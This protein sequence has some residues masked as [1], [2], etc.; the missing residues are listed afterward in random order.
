MPKKTIQVLGIFA[1]ACAVATG[2]ENLPTKT[3]VH[4]PLSRFA[5][6]PVPEYVF[7]STYKVKTRSKVGIFVISSS[8]S[9]FG[10]NLAPFGFAGKRYL[11]TAA[12]VI[13]DDDHISD[14]IEVEVRNKIFRDKKNPKSGFI[15]SRMW[16]RAR[17][18]TYD[19]EMDI[20]ILKVEMDLPHIAE[21]DLEPDLKR[22]AP[23]LAV[24]CPSG[25]AITPSWGYLTSKE[26]ETKH[27]NNFWWQA[28]MPIYYGN[29]GGAV[30]NPKSSKIIGICVAI[31]AHKGPAANASFFVSPDSIKMFLGSKRVIKAIK[32]DGKLHPSIQLPEKYNPSKN[33]RE[34]KNDSRPKTSTRVP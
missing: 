1:F 7:A 19:R 30:W 10:V 12:H 4:P 20:A 24:G 33:T 17:V 16:I 26:S 13:L 22:G 6:P 18:I 21:L 31:I 25:T 23:L 9:A 27:N 11:L 15:V 8:G 3:E 14:R 2:A 5:P 32:R 29:S 28:S 34:N